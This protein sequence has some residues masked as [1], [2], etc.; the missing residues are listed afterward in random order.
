MCNSTPMP[1]SKTPTPKTVRVA[2]V[3]GILADKV[4]RQ[5]RPVTQAELDEAIALGAIER[6]LGETPSESEPILSE[7]LVNEKDQ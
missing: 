1:K 5:G 6:C 4:R 7:S 3:C 2:D